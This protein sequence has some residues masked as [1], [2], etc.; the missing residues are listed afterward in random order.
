MGYNSTTLHQ[1]LLLNKSQNQEQSFEATVGMH[2]LQLDR[3]CLEK[4]LLVFFQSSSCSV[5]VSML[6]LGQQPCQSHRHH[7]FPQSDLILCEHLRKPMTCSWAYN[8]ID[9]IY[10]I[11]L[12]S[13]LYTIL[14]F[15]IHYIIHISNINRRYV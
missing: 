8:W 3:W 1:V 13:I 2:S 10:Y 5:L 15:I 11:T 7:I 12:N 9:F 14:Y 4:G 6:L